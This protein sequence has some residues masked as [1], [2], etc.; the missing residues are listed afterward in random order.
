MRAGS[1]AEDF[2]QA[3]YHD[4]L[5]RSLDPIGRA[6]WLRLLGPGSSLATVVDSI[7]HSAEAENRLV[8]SYYQQYLDRA[9]DIVGLTNWSNFL[10]AGG[11]DETFQAGILSSNE[12]FATVGIRQ[13]L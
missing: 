11:S 6:A 5:G 8:E 3:V 10:A 13:G 2:L 12:F 1:T 7:L 9:A 4:V